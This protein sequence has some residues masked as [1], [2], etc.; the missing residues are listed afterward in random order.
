MCF[1]AKWKGLAAILS[2][3]L[4][5]LPAYSWKLCARMWKKTCSASL[6]L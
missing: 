5:L 4:G 1:K 2:V 3:L 6:Q